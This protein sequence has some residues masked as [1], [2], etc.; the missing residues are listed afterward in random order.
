MVSGNLFYLATWSSNQKTIAQT[1][2]LFAWL[3]DFELVFERLTNFSSHSQELLWN[4]DQG[5]GNESFQK[6]FLPETINF[7]L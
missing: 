4:I 6:K 7:F 3:A 1:R 5:K 2:N